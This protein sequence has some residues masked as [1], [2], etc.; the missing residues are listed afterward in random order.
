MSNK[1]DK[2]L[3]PATILMIIKNVVLNTKSDTIKNILGNLPLCVLPQVITSDNKGATVLNREVLPLLTRKFQWN[4][5]LQELKY[6]W[7][8]LSTPFQFL[9]S[10]C[11]PIYALNL[12]NIF[13]EAMNSTYF[14][15]WQLRGSDPV[16]GFVC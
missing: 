14:V 1:R 7:I 15:I 2:L 5:N 12:N 4:F 6:I 16:P 9:K 8:H 11:F 13:R 10:H 3:V